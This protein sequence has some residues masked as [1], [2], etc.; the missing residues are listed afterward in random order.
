MQRQAPLQYPDSPEA[1]SRMG[2]YNAPRA[3]GS[4]ST[5]ANEI[6]AG[7]PPSYYIVVQDSRGLWDPSTD[8]SGARLFRF[9]PDPQAVPSVASTHAP[10]FVTGTQ[11][12][13][14]PRFVNDVQ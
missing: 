8:S 12:R 2:M 11:P 7:K 13:P 5:T 4:D 10:G 9:R 14:E 6:A 1:I 3:L